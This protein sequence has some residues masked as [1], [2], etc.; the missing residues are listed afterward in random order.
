MEGTV[1]PEL[2]HDFTCAKLR[3]MSLKFPLVL[4][5]ILLIDN[6]E[7]ASTPENS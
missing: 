4:I 7:G 3:V 1:V 6:P 2:G 5:C